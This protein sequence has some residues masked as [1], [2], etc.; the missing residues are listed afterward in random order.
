M[1]W[2]R[3]MALV[4][5][6]AGLGLAWNVASGRG[7]GLSANVFLKPGDDTIDVAEA[8]RRHERGAILFVDARIR[9]VWELE[10]IPGALSVPEDE[11]GTAFE[12]AEPK[13][14]GRYDVVVYC[15]GFGC[16]AS[17]EVARQLKEH[18]IPA[19]ILEGGFPAWQDAGLPTSSE[20]AS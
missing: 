3:V 10:R 12:E 11:F 5:L 14:R 15:D 19:A 18:G 1:R 17:H 7:I 4:I 6:G 20:N 16:E 2:N 9:L 8:G 13:L